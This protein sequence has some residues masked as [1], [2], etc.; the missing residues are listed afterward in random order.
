MRANTYFV[1]TGNDEGNCYLCE[2][3]YWA[4]NG[5]STNE[6]DL[7]YFNPANTECVY[8]E[9]SSTYN[10]ANNQCC[11]DVSGACYYPQSNYATY[12]AGTPKCNCMA[13]DQW[14]TEETCVNC[15]IWYIYTGSYFEDCPR[16]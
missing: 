4:N 16:Y 9:P 8:C 5:G 14:F 15:L 12:V 6:W 13:G 1:S 10:P 3:D 7:A 2:A 11:P